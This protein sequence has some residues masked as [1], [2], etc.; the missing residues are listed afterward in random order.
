[1]PK[2]DREQT[3][4]PL[5]FVAIELHNENLKGQIATAIHAASAKG[6]IRG[7]RRDGRG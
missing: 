7:P 2:D 6:V 1:M 4:G 5:Q 3:I